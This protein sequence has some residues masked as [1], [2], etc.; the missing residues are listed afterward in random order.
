MATLN[1][2]DRTIASELR[3]RCEQL[4]PILDC[5]I[6]GSRARGDASPESDLDMYLV[7][8]VLTRALKRALDDVAWQVGFG[9]DRVV[10]LLVV[11]PT[12]LSTGFVGANPLIKIIE[13]E[14]VAI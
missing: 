10:A 11:T 8:P 1:P 5:R 7:V 4:T 12:D 13:R 2:E 14:G 3:S 9:H 6:Y